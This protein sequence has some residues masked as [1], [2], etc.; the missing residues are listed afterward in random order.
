ELLDLAGIPYTVNPRLVRGLD[1]YNRT[2]FEW[3]TT[4]LGSQG[5]VCGG[6]RYDGLVEQLG[7]RVTP[8]VGFAMGLE[9]L[10]LLVQ[11]V[12]PDFAAAARVDAYLVAAG[13]GVQREAL[14]LAEQLRDDLPSLRLMTNYGGG[15]FKKQFGRADKHGAR[16]ALVLGESEAAAGQVVVKDLAT[17]NQETLAQSDVTARLASILG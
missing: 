13:D 12:N 9:R 17:G 10:L 3:L 1:Y 14:R 2:V 7:G 16:I 5:T 4:R 11:A 15:S 8:A 6:G